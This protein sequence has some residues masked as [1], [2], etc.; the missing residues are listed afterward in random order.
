MSPVTGFNVMA[1]D[2]G[3]GCVVEY[4]EINVTGCAGPLN[5]FTNE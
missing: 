1:G 5:G 3:I 2:D 4:G